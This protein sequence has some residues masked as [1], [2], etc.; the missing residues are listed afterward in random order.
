MKKLFISVLCL[1]ALAS[2][3]RKIETEEINTRTVRVSLQATVGE[4]TRATYDEDLKAQWETGDE[5]ALWQGV[6]G[7]QKAVL[8]LSG[9]G[10]NS[11]GKAS[12]TFTGSITTL[13]DNAADFHYSYPA[14]AL[15]SASGNYSYTVPITQSGKW[16][17]FLYGSTASTTIDAL[18]TSGIAFPKSKTSAIAIRVWD[19]TG[20]KKHVYNKITVAGITGNIAGT[21]TDEGVNNGSKFITCNYSALYE[22]TG[23]YTKDTKTVEYIEYDINVLPCASTG[24]LTITVYPYDSDDDTSFVANISAVQLSELKANFRHG[25]NL[26]LH[27]G[28]ASVS[29][30]VTFPDAEDGGWIDVTADQQ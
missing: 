20:T 29:S 28:A 21:L 25:I 8:S 15:T 10:S 1:A 2:C 26:T 6:T 16:T 7:A 17:P 30:G 4:T 18:Q 14:S 9:A 11:D 24:G 22:R 5:I 12:G 3:S 27:N 23:S 19:E 13:T